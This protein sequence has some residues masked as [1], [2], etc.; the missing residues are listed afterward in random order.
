MC[1]KLLWERAKNLIIVFLLILNLL[2]AA[3]LYNE[4]NRFTLSAE[5]E[6][7]VFGVLANN[8]ITMYSE[9]I[10]SFRPMRALRLSGHAYDTDSLLKMFFGATD[11]ART[12][13]GNDPALQEYRDGE[14]RLT[15][16]NGYITY[17]RFIDPN[18]DRAGDEIPSE[19]AKALCDEFINAFFPD[20]K[21]DD[22]ANDGILEVTYDGFLRLVYRQVFDGYFVYRNF[23]DFLISGNGIEYIEMQYGE[24][25]EYDNQPREICAPDEALLTFIQ[26]IRST[27]PDTPVIINAMDIAYNQEEFSTQASVELEAVPFYR[28]YIDDNYE[29]FLINAYTNVC[30]E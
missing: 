7:A 18:D 25:V 17:Q 6:R 27:H 16:S 29:P 10:R 24:R 23:I 14:G 21:L 13:D 30:I 26:R 19:E 20:Y 2:L 11:I 4:Q 3:L 15:V 5:R 22:L 9:L 1:Y 8:K 28:V 12:D